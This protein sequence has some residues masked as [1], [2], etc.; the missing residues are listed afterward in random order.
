MEFVTWDI[1]LIQLCIII[2]IFSQIDAVSLV[3]RPLMYLIWIITIAYYILNNVRH[4][5]F[6][7]FTRIYCLSY[8]MLVIL[9][10]MATMFGKNHLNGN[11]LHIYVNTASCYI[12]RMFFW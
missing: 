5:I 11:Y 3:F 8:G 10:V 12:C 2:S 1:R 4:I 6:Q 9:C 7:K